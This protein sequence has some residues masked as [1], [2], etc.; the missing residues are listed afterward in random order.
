VTSCLALSNYFEKELA[1]LLLTVQTYPPLNLRTDMKR[2]AIFLG[3]ALAIA[4]VQTLTAGPAP[5]PSGKEMKEVAPAP[6][7]E[8]N[9]TGFYIGVLGGYSWGDIHLR[10]EDDP[11]DDAYHFDQNGFIGGG[12]VG[13][14]WQI[15]MFVIGTELTFA[16]GDWSDSAT[17]ENPAGITVG[18]GRVDSN[19]LGT[20]ATRVGISFWHDHILL[21]AKGGVGF[22]RWEYHTDEVFDLERAHLNDDVRTG[23][24]V[25]GGLEFA[26]NCHWSVKVEYNHIFFG[27]D[28]ENVVERGPGGFSEVTT[29]HA[30]SADRDSIVAGLNFKF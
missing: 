20:V 24:L 25:G 4:I 27:D 28:D 22:T 29:F 21:F 9:W 26:F 7:P 14:N 30:N 16:G 8:C 13:L 10:D 2:F 5:L 23:G 17:I 3:S 1:I 15:G 19:W 6:P 12:G 11:L 18:E